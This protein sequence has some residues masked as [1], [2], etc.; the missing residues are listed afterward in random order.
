MSP[1]IL[2][3][4]SQFVSHPVPTGI[5]RTL[6]FLAKHWPSDRFV[7]E[8][9]FRLHGAH[10]E[11][12]PM[13][14]FRNAIEQLFQ[15]QGKE[16]AF[17]PGTAGWMYKH[18][19][20][21]AT[22]CIPYQEIPD[23]YDGYL[24]PEPTFYDHVIDTAEFCALHMGRR[25]MA[26]VYDAIPQTHPCYYP[27]SHTGATDRYYLTLGK[28][29]SLGFIS[30]E[31]QKIYEDRLRRAPIP[32]AFVMPLGAD[33][34]G[35]EKNPVPDVP[36]FIVPGTI[37]PRKKHQEILS[38][39][40]RLWSENRKCRLVFSGIPGWNSRDFIKRLRK[41]AQE[42]DL[43]TWE[44]RV[45]D[46]VMCEFVRSASAV[47]YISECEGYGLPPMES[48]ALGCPVIVSDNLPSMADLPPD[49]QLRLPEVSEETIAT[50]V[51]HLTDP[52]VNAGFRQAIAH[53]DLPSWERTASTFTEW[54]WHTL[55]DSGRQAH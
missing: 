17:G 45:T 13:E 8:A 16:A 39:F 33:A 34:L 9:G 1:R 44:E 12:V 54:L 6:Y 19:S 27:G 47:I 38:A 4:L 42:S 52:A 11:I 40:E 21:R 10:Y 32:N 14:I 30:A 55:A 24:L 26:M 20:E 37:E 22:S 25:C 7:A 53:L 35:R 18:L 51:A 36:T 28:F 23:N 5:Q 3:D 46:S 15:G 49:G 29:E 50:A 48:L 2:F 41:L 31:S 43:F